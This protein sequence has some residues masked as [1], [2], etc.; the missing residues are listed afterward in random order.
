MIQYHAE[1]TCDECEAKEFFDG[2]FGFVSARNAGWLMLAGQHLCPVCQVATPKVTPEAG[3]LLLRAW[4]VSG[5][6]HG[7]PF[8]AH[9]RARRRG[10]GRLVPD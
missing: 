4:L 1:V 6:G 8:R 7:L 3:P 9:R 10:E 2:T 5:G